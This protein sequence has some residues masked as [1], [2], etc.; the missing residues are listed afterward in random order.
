MMKKADLEKRF[1]EGRMIERADTA[2][3]PSRLGSTGDGQFSLIELLRGTWTSE[4]QGWNLIALPFPPAPDKF[5]LLMNQY[6]ETL[7]FDVP[8]KGVPNRGLVPDTMGATAD[9]SDETDQLIDAIA[10]EQIVIQKEVED[11]PT[12]SV[13]EKN[14]NPIHHEPGFFLQLLNHIP[15]GHT[16]EDGKK[17]GPDEELKIARLATI[18][19]GNSVLAMGTV[20]FI[21]GAPNIPDENALPERINNIDVNTNTF[22]SPYRHFEDNHFF[23]NVPPTVPGF[24]GFFPTDANAILKFA[25]PGSRVKRTTVLHFDTKFR[26]EQ[27]TGTPISNIPFITREADTTEV[28]ATFWIMELLKDD[29]SAPAEFIMQYSQTVYLEFFDSDEPG[30]RIRWPHVSINTLRKT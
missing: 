7:R 6:G 23:G 19:H 10:Y 20:Q 9:P 21:A 29:E 17:N 15:I 26:N 2:T 13:R 24:P 4:A 30:K 27:L 14:G 28:H 22:L 25:N 18:P 11:F 16:E 5:R 8:D 3:Q 1:S 12:S